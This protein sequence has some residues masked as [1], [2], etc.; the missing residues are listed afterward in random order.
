MRS[1]ITLVLAALVLVGLGVMITKKGESGL[2]SHSDE[3]LRLYD[4][5]TRD[6]N[7]FR[8]PEAIVKLGQSLDLD[9]TFA[10]AAI[11][12]TQGLARLGERG[13]MNASLALADSLVGDITN[14]KRRMIAELRL[15]VYNKSQF[16]V[17]HDSLLAELRKSD[18][19]NFHVLVALAGE[20]QSNKDEEAFE[21]AWL[22]ILANDPS[23]ASSYNNLGYFELNRGNYQQAIEYMQKYSFLAPDLAN[24]YD[25]LGE[26]L[27]VIGRYEEAEI[28]F[29][30]AVRIQEDFYPSLINIGKIYI[31]RGQ[32][33]H[34]VD[35][36]EQVRKEFSGSPLAKQVDSS[37][38]LSYLVAGLDPEFGK[39]SAQ[40]ITTFPDDGFSCTLRSILLLKN[41]NIETAISLMD[42]TIM[43]MKDYDDDNLSDDVRRGI[44]NAEFQFKGLLSDATGDY[45]TSAVSWRAAVDS[46]PERATHRTRYIRFRLANAL[47]EIDQPE[48][49]LKILDNMLAVNP[50]L[51][52][53]L[54]LKVKCHLVMDAG[55]EARLALDQLQWS[56]T[57]ADLD[58]P[59]RKSAN[60]LESKAPAIA[61]NR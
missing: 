51:I 50:R 22:D 59:A 20:A 30:S 25:S 8:L 14:R 5:G 15:S 28:E 38:A 32:I 9:P 58:F 47:Y 56:L 13:K 3:A 23:Y 42:S 40:F 1:L 44:N 52:G 26:V 46:N 17:M 21:K 39:V 43:A 49:S 41:D 60:D 31:E 57:N 12:Q 55:L 6:L 10:E 61:S 37:V 54:L 7:A 24:P 48:E 34:G 53:A 19:D 36:L 4:E 45:A 35:L 18:P 2:T 16:F 27:M 29:V 11:S 33:E